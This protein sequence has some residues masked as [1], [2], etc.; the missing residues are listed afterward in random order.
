MKLSLQEVALITNGKVVCGSP[1]TAVR[2]LALDS[3]QMA[4][5]DLFVALPGERVDGH[6]FVESAVQHGAAAALVM[7]DAAE[8][9]TDAAATTGKDAAEIS[10]DSVPCPAVRVENTRAALQEL[11]RTLRDRYPGIVVGV[12]GSVGKT[13]TRELLKAALSAAGSVTGNTGNLNSQVGL[14][15]A[16]AHMDAEA[17]FAVLEMGI[18]EP[19]EMARLVSIAQPDAALV[20]NIGVAHIENLGSREGICREKMRIAEQ[21]PDGAP[22][23]LNGEEPLLRARAAELF[24]EKTDAG[25]K[26]RPVF[27]GWDSRSEAYAEEICPEGAAR[28]TA[29]LTPPLA[30]ATLRVP[31][32]LGVP[33]RHNVLN[34]L[35]ALTMAVLLGAD[36]YAAAAALAGFTGEKR[37]LEHVALGNLLL[38]DDAYNAG[39]ESARAALEDLAATSAARRIAVL[40]DMLEL[41]A[42]SEELHREWGRFAAAL[43]IDLFVTVGTAIRAAEEV[44]TE[45]GKTVLHVDNAEQAAQILRSLA[46]AG[47]A[48][49]LKASHGIQL[50]KVREA[51]EKD[52]KG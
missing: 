10:A 17:D 41:G 12:T 4:G 14:P 27:Y 43:P 20:T 36:P 22:L 45:R 2:H 40:G 8:I 39:P 16:I 25:R 23:V 26:I 33:G 24:G 19:G 28:Y 18:S 13:T 52:L 3:R 6:R 48:V 30:P 46:A 42:H 21:L 29:V 11:G 50:E 47:D 5:E 9:F 35:G 51:L 7:K 15:V 34:S 32:Q 1:E 38:I 49:L 37:R 31:V 44:L